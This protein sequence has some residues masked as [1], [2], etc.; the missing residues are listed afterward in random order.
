MPTEVI[1]GPPNPGRLYIAKERVA[2]AFVELAPP[3]IDLFKL[4]KG[5][6]W[7]SRELARGKGITIASVKSRLFK[8]REGM[9]RILRGGLLTRSKEAALNT[10][11]FQRTR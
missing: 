8:A 5:E 7:T 6:G 9:Q 3:L 10:R 1:D 11:K 4:N 2:K